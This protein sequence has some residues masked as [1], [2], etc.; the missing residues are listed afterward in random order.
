MRLALPL[1]A[2]ALASC[3]PE[4][5]PVRASGDASVAPSSLQSPV[6]VVPPSPVDAPVP[7]LPQDPADLAK[8]AQLAGEVHDYVVGRLVLLR[9]GVGAEM[10]RD[11]LAY[12]VDRSMLPEEELALLDALG[13]LCG[14]VNEALGATEL[15]QQKIEQAEDQAGVEILASL[16]PA[17]VSGGP[18]GLSALFSTLGSGAR[19]DE[20]RAVEAQRLRQGPWAPVDAGMRELELGLAELRSNHQ[21]SHPSGRN[22]FLDGRDATRL[23]GLTASEQGVDAQ[24]QLATQ[25][26]GTSPSYQAAHVLLAQC[27][28]AKGR[29]ADAQRHAETAIALKPSFLARDPLRASAYKVLAFI[30]H[31]GKRYEDSNVYVESG[32]LDAPSDPYLVMLFAL[33]LLLQGEYEAALPHQ[34]RLVDLAPGNAPAHYNLACCLS[35]LELDADR[36]FE[37]LGKAIELGYREMAHAQEDSDLN[38]IR[39]RRPKQFREL[40]EPQVSLLLKWVLFRGETLR[41]RNDSPFEFDDVSV[42]IKAQLADGT[43]QVLEGAVARMERGKWVDLRLDIDAAKRSIRELEVRLR[44]DQGVFSRTL[45]TSDL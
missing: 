17:V 44:C 27:L 2:V 23:D 37:H 19:L 15:S 8:A 43:E 12:E 42:S 36:A 13:A 28:L 6:E 25:I 31:S 4:E 7:V 33:N 45:D 26:V 14:D 3:S 5:V 11:E 35:K 39:F 32:L 30:E 9:R 34:Q 10:I 40:T 18:L 22:G 20:L 1:L 29:A 41:M 16:F 21:Q 24:L 38:W